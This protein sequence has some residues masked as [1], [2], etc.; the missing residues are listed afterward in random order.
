ML[1]L[2]GPAGAQEIK[3]R[4]MPRGVIVQAA[5]ERFPVAGTTIDEITMGMRSAVNAEGGFL[6]H[7]SVSWRYNYGMSEQGQKA[8]CRLQNVRVDMQTRIRIPDWQ[9]A[10]GATPE[11]TAAWSTF[12]TAFENHVREHENIAI[13]TAGD[14]VQKLERMTDMSCRQLQLDVQREARS[15]SERMD[16]RQK[17]LDEDTRHGATEGARWPPAPP[18]ARF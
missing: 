15:S 10:P 18:P 11:A 8:G 9:T 4:P 16:A 2:A 17:K 12:Q 3:S 7:Y 5:V 14:F 6:G 1:P 13:R